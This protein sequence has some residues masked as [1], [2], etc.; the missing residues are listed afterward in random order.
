M[1]SVGRAP[2]NDIKD[3]VD[4]AGGRVRPHRLYVRTYACHRYWCPL[5]RLRLYSTP[6]GDSE[7]SCFSTRLRMSTTDVRELHSKGCVYDLGD[8]PKQNV[9]IPRL[10]LCS[11]VFLSFQ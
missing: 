10:N 9:Q 11:E 2:R 6:L 5:Y 4:V 8:L 1:C 7:G 3:K